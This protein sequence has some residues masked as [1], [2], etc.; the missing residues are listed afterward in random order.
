[1]SHGIKTA[2]QISA[3]LSLRKP[4]SE[5]L[6]LLCQILEQLKLDKEPELQ[7]WLQ[8][9]QQDHASFKNFERSFPSLCFALA[10]GVGKTRLMGAMIA[11]LYLTGRS[12]HFFV[13][14]PNLTIYEKLKQDF[15]PGSP[16]YVFQGIS[17]LADTPP[18]LITGDDYQEGRGVRLDYAM[19][20]SMTGDLFAAETAPHI[21]IFNISKI[22][23]LD[24]KQGAAKS[25]TAKVRRIQEYIGDSYF[26]YLAELPDLVVLMDE[27]HRYYASAGAKALNDLKP[28]LGIELTATPKT[29]GANPK[30]F[31]NIIYHYPLAS[32]LN[33]GYVKIPAVATRKDFKASSYSPEQLEKLK[34]EDGIHHHEYVKT[35]LASYA[36]NTGKR[37]VKPFMLVVAQDTQHAELIKERI[38]D[39]GFFGGAYKGKVI[40]VHSNQSG[41]ES[42]E[43]TQRL[44]AVEHDKDTEIVIHVNKLKEGWDVTNLYTI[45]PLRASASEIL[46]EQT[47]GRGLRLPYGKRTG[48][49]AVDRLTII[50]H[51]RFQEIIDKANDKESII[52]KTLYIGSEDDE[53]GIPEQKPKQMVVPST[54][55]ALLVRQPTDGE[56]REVQDRSPG[57]QGSQSTQPPLFETESEKKVAELTFKIV[58]EEAKRLSSSKELGSAEVKASLAKKVQQAMHELM[59][60]P[61][62]T[63]APSGAETTTTVPKPQQ[64]PLTRLDDSVIN[65]L[66]AI[67]TDKLVEH[68]IDI[69]Q[70]VIL[71][72][73][74]VNYGFTEFDLG[75]LER[76]SLKPGSKEML[77]QH[78][79]DNRTT[80]I[81]WEDGGAEE[82]RLEDYLVRYLLDHN[83]IDYEEHAGSLYKLAGQMVAHLQGYLSDEEA[84]S[85][86]KT[87]GRVLADFIWAQMR[88]HMWTTPT[89]YKG[90]ITKGFDVLHP[91][92]FNYAYNEQPRDFR[93]PIQSGEKSRI[94]QMLFTGFDKCC[95]PY[96]KFDSVDGEWRL[97]QILENDGDV[98]KWMKPAPGQFKIEYANGQNYEPDFV[99]ETKDAFLLMEPK[100]AT[101]V[102]SPEVQAKAR[103]A[104]RWCFYANE[105]AKQHGGKTWHYVLIPHSDIELG[106]TIAGL[107]QEFEIMN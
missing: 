6:Q 34:L 54:L 39:S 64:Q 82:E 33:D 2:N 88:N 45:V 72:T 50:A 25:K 22:N 76:I 37:L 107:I 35:E 55:E 92:T 40:T 32:A 43:N 97:A 77:L 63:P 47:I 89:D 102:D 87:Q 8:V 85:L 46:T 11:W 80:S 86:L 41:E 91:A 81:S 79:E 101:E 44:L 66:V 69:P 3:R 31:K 71:P 48:V 21:N 27:A 28:V 57:Y 23:A 15:L 105:H 60:P 19:T 36:N 61:A 103:A 90:V 38:E 42:E 12:S 17:E 49:E 94:R 53:N 93:A 65:D 84:E 83:E 7:Q 24:N 9:I 73:R 78:L 59:P 1:M 5:S 98:L 67:I 10:T 13:L 75:G 99:V 18:V 26:N 30:D 100:K 52:K 56:G 74:E 104:V 58:S 62:S 16:K 14:A 95:Y 68:T 4:Q 20:Q 70:I 29:V 51:D 106:R 96:Q